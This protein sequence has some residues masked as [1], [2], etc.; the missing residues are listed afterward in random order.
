[1]GA[2]AGVAAAATWINKRRLSVVNTSSDALIEPESAELPIGRSADP[3]VD[4]A[5]SRTRLP[6]EETTGATLQAERQPFVDEPLSDGSLDDIW[7]AGARVDEAGAES[8]DYDAVNPESLGGVWLERAT[9]TTHGNR[10]HGSDPSDLAELETVS[11]S[12]STL[13]SSGLA[14]ADAA[15]RADD[16]GFDIDEEDE[17]RNS[18]L[19]L[20]IEYEGVPSERS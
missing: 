13:A 2:A 19:D 7:N 15:E 17:I 18:E 6:Q 14:E 9:Q 11:V 20:P 12:E 4:E 8:E 1:M 16:E 10:A 5:L 3:E